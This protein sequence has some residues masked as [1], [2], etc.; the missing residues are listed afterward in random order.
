MLHK[1]C[2]LILHDLFKKLMEVTTP[3]SFKGFGRCKL[4]GMHSYVIIL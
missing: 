1:C 2:G 4:P 3:L